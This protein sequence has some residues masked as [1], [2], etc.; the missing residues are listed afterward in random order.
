[1]P[2][3]MVSVIST[4]SSSHY[5]AHP[6]AL[7]VNIHFA[8]TFFSC[9]HLLYENGTDEE[10]VVQSCGLPVYVVVREFKALTFCEHMASK[11]NR[12][13]QHTCYLKHQMEIVIDQSNKSVTVEIVWI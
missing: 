6:T 2:N 11:H 7:H 5:Q 3:V 9:L 1:M 4:D 8:P 12:L 13:L 10:A